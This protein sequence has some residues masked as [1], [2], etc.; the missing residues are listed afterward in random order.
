MALVEIP[1]DNSLPSYE[2]AVVLDGTQYIIALNFNPRINDGA[3][4]WFLTL[5]DQNRNMLV[6]PVPVVVSWPLV[7][8]FIELVDLPGM[9]MAFD[10]SGNNEDPGQFDLGSRVRLYYLEAGSTL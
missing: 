6:A 7:D 1:T 10:T 5:A 8:R 2:Q 3:G 4:K 9:I